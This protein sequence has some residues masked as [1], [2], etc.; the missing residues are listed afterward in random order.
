MEKTNYIDQ[1]NQERA[2]KIDKKIVIL[3]KE[4]INAKAAYHRAK[5]NKEKKMSMIKKWENDYEHIIEKNNI[6]HDINTKQTQVIIIDNQLVELKQKKEFLT[7]GQTQKHKAQVEKITDDLIN[8]LGWN[9][10]EKTI[11]TPYESGRKELSIQEGKDSLSDT[12]NSYNTDDEHIEYAPQNSIEWTFWNYAS[13]AEQEIYDT[14]DYGLWNSD[15]I[16]PA[17]IE[18][19]EYYETHE[20]I[21]PENTENHSKAD[22]LDNQYEDYDE[23]FYEQRKTSK[24]SKKRIKDYENFD[25]DFNTEDDHK[26]RLN[27]TNKEF[28]GFDKHNSKNK[29]NYRRYQHVETEPANRV[30]KWVKK[31]KKNDTQKDRERYGLAA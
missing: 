15:D 29:K 30:K 26:I 18:A 5:K 4:L 12:R 7:W 3:E 9:Y 19:L 6:E 10:K 17:L 22:S 11:S 2:E 20:D 24:S 13:D 16:S 8:Q 25:E 21:N 31:K 1:L 23:D 28:L 14:A 27:W